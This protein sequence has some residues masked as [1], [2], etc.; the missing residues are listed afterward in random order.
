MR[1]RFELERVPGGQ[2][3]FILLMLV[4]LLAGC[5]IAALFSAS[6]Y[7]AEKYF[8][9]SF[10]FI[11]KQLILG[12]VGAVFGFIAFKLSSEFLRRWTPALL[13]GS[14]VLMLL[15]FLPGLSEEIL[16]A[17]RWI[18]LF[19]FSFQP[20]ELVKLA[21]VLYLANIFEK[22]QDR[23]HDFLNTVLPSLIVLT[24]VVGLVLLQNDFSSAIFILIIGLSMF[25]MAGVPLLYFVYLLLAAVPTSLIFLFTKPHRVERLIAFISPEADPVGSGY[26]VIAAQ[27][28]L[29]NGGFIGQ[30]LGHGIKKLG[31][32]PEVHSD[33]IFAST[34]EEVGF[35]GVFCI[36]LLFLGF[37]ARAIL[38]GYRS[39][40][41]YDFLLS[42]GLAVCIL[43]QALFNMAVVSGLVPATGI[44][45]PFF[46]S[47]GSSLFVT[48]LMC[49]L[50]LGT[51]RRQNE[52]RI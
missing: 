47:G 29:K 20:S 2:S 27:S 35:M 44:P 51:T 41:H 17:R 40:S 14:L 18:F 49:G 34:A 48:F 30:G 11:R 19:G 31:G 21:I 10:L 25:F 50:L 39:G 46:S 43:Y 33:F 8:S 24:V 26:Q 15:T 42:F 36:I 9:D 37:G 4:V 38:R 23:M 52:E 6:Y 12:G 45:L 7:Y 28:A 32:L 22:K 1:G 5:G 16:G 3:D 13:L